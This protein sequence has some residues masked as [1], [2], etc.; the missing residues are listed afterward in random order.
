[1]KILG[2]HA[3]YF[4]YEAREKALKKAENICEEHRKRSFNNILVCFVTVEKEDE[5]NPEKIA[6]IAK[7]EILDSVKKLGVK[8]VLLYPYAHLSENLASPSKALEVLR[9]LLQKLSNDVKVSR[10]PFGWYKR[11]TITCIGHPLAEFSKTIKL[12]AER[13]KRED[14][15]IL[16]PDGT[17]I[18]VKDYNSVEL[19]E[20]FKVLVEKE[21]LKKESP[22]G[23]PKYLEYCKRFGFE[24]EPMSDIG[25]MRYGPEAT[26]ILEA[27][28]EY[29]WLCAKS[30]GLPIFKVRGTNMFDLE[31]KPVKQHAELFGDRLYTLE[32]DDRKYVLRY[33]ACHQ[34][35]A[36]IKDWNI[37]YKN[38]PFGAFE[39]ADSYRLEQPGELTLC[40]RMRKFIMPDLHIFCK[41]LQEAMSI[42]F[43]IHEKI[44]EEIRKIGRDYF[45]IYNLTRSFYENNK[46]YVMKLV[47][48]EK[49]PV[50]LHFVPE[51]KYY[52]VINIE[53][54]IVDQLKRPREI[55][56]FQ[57]DIGNAKR[58]GIKYTDEN[59]VKRYPVIIH[60]ALIGSLERFIY[61]LFDTAVKMEEEGKAPMLPVWVSP[62]QVRLIPFSK[63]FIEYALKIAKEIN[64][65][66]IRADIDDREESIPKKIRD[67]ERKWIP[68]I[69]VLGKKEIEKGVL[70]VRRRR[71]R[72]IKEY[73]LE[74]LIKEINEEVKGY[75][76]IESTLP[77]SVN[78]RPG[79]R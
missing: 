10:A 50:L 63:E 24:W 59:N 64:S 35:F 23:E 7:D 38:L 71:D 12:D 75:P 31:Y 44:Y 78:V 67:A 11:F 30:L 29:S 52:W 48:F 34:Q 17:E 57:I 5:A 41:D 3:E 16:L 20:D 1:M 19:L 46:E 58:F 55:G 69:I 9:L 39:I 36:M 60:T 13:P 2:I 51:N 45:S 21:A 61:V 25:H 66:G 79:Y 56:T 28:S 62:I 42:S 32:V 14:Y 53:Y 43:K 22:G 33:A 27:V 4:E 65:K 68:Y 26:L 8:E 76:K 6:E 40:F 72:K 37:S 70:S 15:L 49:K 18:D 73:T 77:L 54:N 74:E 47:K